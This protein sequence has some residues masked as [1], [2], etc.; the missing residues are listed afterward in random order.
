MS[1]RDKRGQR[2]RRGAL[3]EPSK[4][5]TANTVQLCIYCQQSEAN[6]EEHVIAR[7]FFG[8]MPPNRYVKVPACKEC[9]EGRGDGGTRPMSQD[10]EYVRTVIAQEQR[11]ARHPV[12]AKLLAEEIP[13]S[14][15]NSP[16]FLKRIGSH[17]RLANVQTRSGIVIP[18]TPVI[19]IENARVAR[20][21]QKI[22]RG[23]FYAGGGKPLPRA[24]PIQIYAPRDDDQVHA[25]SHLIDDIQNRSPLIHVGEERAFVFKAGMYSGTNLSVWMLIFYENMVFC[26]HTFPT[27]N[28]EADLEHPALS[29]TARG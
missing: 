26:A 18:N 2:Q 17:M 3:P 19:E 5:Q 29:S 1:N 7:A 12:A 8:T 6:S 4:P 9:N 27:K 15:D 21:M 25:W 28:G 14:F 20:V 10:E 11:S 24:W 22:V 23:L 13:R 16:G